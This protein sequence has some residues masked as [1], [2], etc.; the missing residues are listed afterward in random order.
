[1]TRFLC[2]AAVLPS[3]RH[4]FGD[5]DHVSRSRRTGLPQRRAAHPA[6]NHLR[7]SGE[8]RGADRPDGKRLSYLAPVDGV[9][10]VWVGPV[11]DVA[12]AKP[13]TDDKKRGIRSYFW[14]YTSKHILYTQDNDGDEN[15]HVYGV[16]LDDG[17]DQDLTP[18]KG[19]A[20]QIEAVE[21]S[22]PER[23]PGRPQRSRRAAIT[24]STASTSTPASGSSSRRTSRSSPASSPT[25]T[26]RFASPAR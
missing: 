14:A 19:V 12:A 8:G 20:A 26:S 13:V 16:D 22:L 25:K 6:R 3:P 2:V 9:L 21:R 1:M 7:Q 15:W 18:I 23:D 10:N 5:D 17:R 24:T 11:D 4:L